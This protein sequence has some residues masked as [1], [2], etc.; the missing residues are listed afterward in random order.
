MSFYNNFENLCK[1]IDKSPSKVATELNIS[2]S[3]VTHWKSQ[4]GKPKAEVL[5]KIADYFSVSVDELL[6]G[7]K[8]EPLESDSL[9]ND[10]QTLIKIVENMSD[11][12][13]KSLLM[14]LR[15]RLQ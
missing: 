12:E 2:R 7:T 14:L 8:K 10:K 13:V 4:N 5:Q 11:E 15:S 3:N 6:S 9:S 1:K